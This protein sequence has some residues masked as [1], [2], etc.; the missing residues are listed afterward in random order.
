MN[1]NAIKAE[2]EKELCKPLGALWAGVEGHDVLAAIMGTSIH[3]LNKYIGSI[4]RRFE[5]DY[6][7]E[8]PKDW[9]AFSN[10][11][12]K[13]RFENDEFKN[14]SAKAED[15]RNASYMLA[16]LADCFDYIEKAELKEDGKE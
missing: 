3:D 13:T 9:D 15:L 10:R 1:A 2:L 14:L 12:S 5:F 4:L 11:V 7:V 16:L 8:R 6:K